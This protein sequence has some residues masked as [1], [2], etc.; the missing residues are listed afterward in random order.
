TGFS[1]LLRDR[2]VG[3]EADPNFAAAL[4]EPGNGHA[5]RLDLAIADPARLQHFQAVLAESKLRATPGL[6]GHASALLLAVLN[7]FRHQHKNQPLVVVFGF[8]LKS[9]RGR[10]HRLCLA[11]FLREDFAFI[12]PC[13]HANHAI[14]RAGLGEAVFNVG[15]QRVER[16]AALQVPLG[17]RDFIAV[18]ATADAHLDSLAAE[19]QGGIDG[20]AHRAPEADAFFQLQRNGFGHKLSIQLGLV[21]FLNIDVNLAVRPLLKLLLQLVDLSSLAADDDSRARRLDDDAQLVAGTLD[22][23]RAHARRFE[24][25]L[26]LVLQL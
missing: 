22:F 19:A 3:E 9:S 12:N 2:L 1:R 13:L 21:N 10:R 7:F 25:V 18:Q 8:W 26:E 4:H 24:L 5:T 14:S 20:L 23:D 11:L 16:E 6:A 15:A 17:T